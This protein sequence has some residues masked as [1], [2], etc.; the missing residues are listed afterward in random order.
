VQGDANPAYLE[1][2]P[3]ST[4]LRVAPYC[5]PGGIRVVSNR[6]RHSGGRKVRRPF[7][8]RHYTAVLL[9]APTT[10]PLPG[11]ETHTLIE[12]C[13][14]YMLNFGTSGDLSCRLVE[15]IHLS[16]S[17]CGFGG[18]ETVWK[19]AEGVSSRLS[20]GKRRLNRDSFNPSWPILEP[21][22]LTYPEFADRF[23]G[24]FRE[25]EA[26]ILTSNGYSKKTGK[27]R[28]SLWS[29]AK[30]IKI[31]PLVELGTPVDGG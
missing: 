2:F 28:A 7:L 6:V 14:R 10:M 27:P 20:S 9:H 17:G 19:I 1:G 5:V 16:R 25:N 8:V 26:I 4:L 30:K 12:G 29:R 31:E 3:F 24:H 15:H 22:F 13:K 18:L 21:R 11:N 23:S